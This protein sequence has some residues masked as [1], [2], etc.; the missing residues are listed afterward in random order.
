VLESR[1]DASL[2]ADIYVARSSIQRSGNLA[3]MWDLMD[4]KSVHRSE[5]K[6]FLSVRSHY[7]YDCGGSRTRMLSATGYAGHMGEGAVNL[8]S[9]SPL[10]WQPLPANAHIR[11]HWNVACGKG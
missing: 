7:E 5:G 9:D 2:D 4:F 10:P 8:S 6:P 3:R 11:D 1:A